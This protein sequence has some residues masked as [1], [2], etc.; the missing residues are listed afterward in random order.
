MTVKELKEQFDRITGPD[1]S[2]EDIA[3][4]IYHLTGGN[5]PSGDLVNLI[6]AVYGP[7]MLDTFIRLF[8]LYKA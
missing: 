5:E 4:A 2:V 3:N 1:T 7:D 6:E 8:I